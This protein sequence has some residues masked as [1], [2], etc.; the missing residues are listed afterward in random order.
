VLLRH[1]NGDSNSDPGDIARILEEAAL[2]KRKIWVGSVIFAEF[3]PKNFIPGKFKTVD[4]FA[5]YIQQIA[6]VISPTPETCL[7]LQ[8][9]ETFGGN[10]LLANGRMMKSQGA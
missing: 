9:S 4:A 2:G 3:R 1:A 5:R 8:G 6:V 10:V 7:W